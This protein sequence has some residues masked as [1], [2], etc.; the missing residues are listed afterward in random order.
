MTHNAAPTPQDG[1]VTWPVVTRSGRISSGPHTA[2][3]WFLLDD[4]QSAASW[5]L[6]SHRMASPFGALPGS[7]FAD[8]ARSLGVALS[9]YV[10][11]R[12][13]SGTGSGWAAAIP[14]Y[15]V[16]LG[17]APATLLAPLRAASRLQPDTA[18]SATLLD[19]ARLPDDPSVVDE[20]YD[21]YLT[22]GRLP[23]HRWIQLAQ[24]LTESD[25]THLPRELLRQ[26]IFRLV[27]E[28]M[29]SINYAYYCRMEAASML[30][31]HPTT[32]PLLL[33]AVTTLA[34]APGASGTRDAWGLL[35]DVADIAT[36]TRIVDRLP[37][38]DDEQFGG[39][40]V[41]LWQ[42]IH[43]G[44]LPRHLSATL[45]DVLIER[46]ATWTLASMEP[47]AVL[48]TAFPVR[49]R[50]RVLAAIDAIHPMA[51]MSGGR[52]A[53]SIDAELAVYLE[54]AEAASWPGHSN[55]VLREMLRVVLSADS[56]GVQFHTTSLLQVSPYA[57]ALTNAALHLIDAPDTSA[58][59]AQLAMYLVSRLATSDNADAVAALVERA[60]PDLAGIG[61]T[62]S[63]HLRHDLGDERLRKLASQP[64][65]ASLAVYYA[66]ISQHPLLHSAAFAGASADWWATRSGGCWD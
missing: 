53:R 23:G 3:T 45:A 43:L 7:A 47:L 12:A 1:P 27:D 29:R 60:E 34:A 19:Q 9:P 28:F 40:C 13:E 51:R 44:L 2:H 52:Q 14:G 6:W 11:S 21:T 63:A 55:S 38:S 56:S 25:S 32:A 33:D 30:A 15:E 59:T 39:F 35:G 17:L 66:G 16:A 62:T 22:G 37:T 31:A 64:H 48:A 41:A 26:W 58:E 57:T 18:E 36:I 65:T 24:L 42:H 8:H 49:H 20:C 46:T 10:M 4:L 50:D 54:F 61:L 5:L